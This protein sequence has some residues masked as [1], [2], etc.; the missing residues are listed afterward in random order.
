VSETPAILKTHFVSALGKTPLGRVT[1]ADIMTIIAALLDRPTTA[2]HAHAAVKTFLNWAV[3][4]NSRAP[5][6]EI[7]TTRFQFNDRSLA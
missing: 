2:M 1:T 3:S 5:Q 7:G 4:R 6:Q